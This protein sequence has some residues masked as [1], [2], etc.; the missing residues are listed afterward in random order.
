MREVKL[1]QAYVVFAYN[2]GEALEQWSCALP[3]DRAVEFAKNMDRTCYIF[4][5]HVQF[6]KEPK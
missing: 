4:E 2:G 6:Y 3:L 1:K 5:R